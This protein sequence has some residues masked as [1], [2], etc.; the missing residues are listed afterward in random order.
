MTRRPWKPVRTRMRVLEIVNGVFHA[1][2][3]LGREEREAARSART[4]SHRELVRRL[5]S[6]APTARRTVRLDTTRMRRW[7]RPCA[8]WPP[9]DVELATGARPWPPPSSSVSSFTMH[10]AVRAAEHDRRTSS[11]RWLAVTRL[12]GSRVPQQPGARVPRGAVLDLEP[13][14]RLDLLSDDGLP[15]PARHRGHAV[16]GAPSAATI[17]GRTSVC[18]RP[19][20]PFR[21]APTTGTSST[22]CGS[23][24]SSP[25]TC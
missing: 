17:P 25:S 20:R 4:A 23:P 16:H 11:A 21:C 8:Q 12:L 1:T 2:R 6:L 22:W 7:P 3:A 9:P 14:I 15:R 19:R 10:L 18:A 5:C 13:R 24:C